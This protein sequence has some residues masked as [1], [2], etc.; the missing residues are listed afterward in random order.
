MKYRNIAT[1]PRWA[2][3]ETLLKNL[4]WKL[5]IKIYTEKETGF[6]RDIVRFEVDGETEKVNQFKLSMKTF[7]AEWNE[8]IK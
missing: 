8:E 7:V 5:D 1:F 4:A 2:H 3:I 6:L